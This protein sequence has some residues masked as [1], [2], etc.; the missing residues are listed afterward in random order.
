[1]TPEAYPFLVCIKSYW[2]IPVKDLSTKM[3][4]IFS[5]F[6]TENLFEKD[7]NGSKFQKHPLC[8][9]NENIVE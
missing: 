2:S 9:K 3:C 5:T 6:C 7:I 8:I 4:N 1:M